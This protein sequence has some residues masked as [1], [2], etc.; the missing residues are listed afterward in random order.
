M[1]KNQNRKSDQNPLLKAIANQD[2]N[3]VIN[4]LKQQRHL[5]QPK[6]PLHLLAS[7]NN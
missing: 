2:V 6:L 1:K 5:V 3:L 4:L 7:Y